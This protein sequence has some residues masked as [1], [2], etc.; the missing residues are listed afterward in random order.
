MDEGDKKL[1][2]L[3]QLD[4]QILLW[5]QD[6]LRFD[7][8]TPFWKVITSLG[9]KGIIWILLTLILLC[10]KKTR[11]VGVLCAFSLVGSLLIDNI[12]L[13]NLVARTRPYEV[14]DGLQLL[15]QKA[16]DYS[17]PSGHAGS[18][19]A[20][21]VV[22]YKKLP[23]KFGISALILAF[24]IAFSRLYA[25]IHYPTDVL[26]AMIIGTAI[27]FFVCAVAKYMNPE[28]DKCNF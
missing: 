2:A 26:C 1:D 4:G 21:A 17:F 20:A 13:K 28:Y 14:I 6:Y 5:I 22:M 16:D 15:V 10:F 9:D 12:I 23:K 18:S 11:K 7:F 27:A 3:V 25:G 8:L 19:F 24:L